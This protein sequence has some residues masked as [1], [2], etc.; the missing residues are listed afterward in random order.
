MTVFTPTLNKADQLNPGVVIW[1]HLTTRAVKSCKAE[2]NF[3]SATDQFKATRTAGQK[4]G[5]G[6]VADN[7]KSIFTAAPC[8][9]VTPD[10]AFI[11][12]LNHWPYSGENTIFKDLLTSGSK[13]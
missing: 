1:W 11:I 6:D 10:A 13:N 9:I 12:A 5:S 3:H 4:F 8:F 2:F 7:L